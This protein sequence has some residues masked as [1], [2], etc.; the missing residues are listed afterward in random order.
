[1]NTFSRLWQYLAEFFLEWEMFK[2][3]VVENIK[4]H[5]TFSN[6]PPPT[7]PAENCAGYAIKSKNMVS[8]RGLGWQCGACALH[9]E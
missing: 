1:M 2:I 5:F 9:A 7:P 8:Q 6:F 3:K 4:T